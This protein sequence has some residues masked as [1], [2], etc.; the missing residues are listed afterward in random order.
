LK[1]SF[2]VKAASDRVDGA[3]ARTTLMKETRMT[4]IK[5]ISGPKRYRALILTVF[6]GFALWLAYQFWRDGA[7]FDAPTGLNR[8]WLPC[9]E[10]NDC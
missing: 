3:N 9:E 6:A 7:T 2:V 8:D 5:E 10:N 4:P 1:T